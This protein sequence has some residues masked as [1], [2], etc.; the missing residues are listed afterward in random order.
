MT[1]PTGVGRGGWRPGSGR[2]P[3]PRP[4]LP[5]ATPSLGSPAVLLP[6]PP[7]GANGDALI[8]AL[9]RLVDNARAGLERRLRRIEQTGQDQTKRLDAALEQL[10]RVLRHQTAIAR[11]LGAVET[12]PLRYTRRRPLGVWLWPPPR[13]VVEALA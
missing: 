13:Q 11:Q 5:E 6:L 4:V 9:H 7:S 8:P 10:E 3:K 12:T 2:K 1:K